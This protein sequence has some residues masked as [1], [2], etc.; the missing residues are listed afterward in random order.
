[1]TQ[2]KLFATSKNSNP[3][4]EQGGPEKREPMSTSTAPPTYEEA[5]L[6]AKNN[7]PSPS[8][9]M[10]PSWAYVDPS[11][12]PSYGSGSF[13]GESE[14]FSSFSWDDKNVRRVFIRKVYIILM[15]QLS[16]TAGVIALFTF[17]DPVR[18]Y[19][20]ARPGWYW[21]SYAVFFVTYM[22]LACCPG[23]RRYF[24]WNLILL[25]IF[26]GSFACML[27]FLSSFYNTKSVL[28]CFTITALV[29]L[30]VTIFSFQTKFDFTSCH[31]VLFVL[32]IVLCI[33]GL[34]LAI[35]LP[36]Q[37]VP[38]L[39]AVYAVLG[40]IIFT[41]FLAFDTQLLIGNRRYAISPEEYI[42]GA[43]NIYLDIIYIFTFMLQI[44][45]S[46]RE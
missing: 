33:S 31:G 10:H 13:S 27:G 42:F 40:A 25:G 8:A 39:H 26:T 16:L 46:N 21:A 19:I 30:A 15:I 9:P 32:L 20:Q 22:T 38:W 1:M 14:L 41:M 23:P 17:C 18:S 6:G 24:P 36:F 5:T 44:F 12:S 28:L 7:S 45:G 43:L 4:S 2:G 34:V 35:V 11:R 29:C 37:Y 3:E